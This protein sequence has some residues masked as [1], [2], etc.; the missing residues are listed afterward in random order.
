VVR[1]MRGNGLAEEEPFDC[2]KG[3]FF[4]HADAGS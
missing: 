1:E 4:R 2:R 3:R